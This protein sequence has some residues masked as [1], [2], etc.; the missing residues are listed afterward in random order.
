MTAVSGTM[1]KLVDAD[2]GLQRPEVTELTLRHLDV[3]KRVRLTSATCASGY[4][5]HLQ[6]AMTSWTY[7]I[8]LYRAADEQCD[9]R[10]QDA[11]LH[12]AAGL[13]QRC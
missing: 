1:N 10:G 6:L 3:C 2:A 9:V 7:R 13:V 12:V 5:S 8:S 4:D 11:V